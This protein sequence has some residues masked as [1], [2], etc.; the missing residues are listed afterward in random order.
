MFFDDQNR[1][2]ADAENLEVA[3]KL[4]RFLEIPSK[5]SNL[6]KNFERVSIG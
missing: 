4:F 6:D 5:L 2:D 1:F 3:D